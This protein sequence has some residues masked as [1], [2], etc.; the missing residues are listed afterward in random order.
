MR[1]FHSYDEREVA[2]PTYSLHSF[3]NDVADVA[4]SGLVVQLVSTLT[5]EPR[6]VGVVVVDEFTHHA[7]NKLK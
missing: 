6:V 7:N 4:A 2:S 1:Y 5:S 3:P